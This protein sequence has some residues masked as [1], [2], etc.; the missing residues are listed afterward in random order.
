MWCEVT[1][2]MVGIV[3]DFTGLHRLLVTV[4]IGLFWI[5]E[6]TTIAIRKQKINPR[7][8]RYHKSSK[9]ASTVDGRILVL[10]LNYSGQCIMVWKISFGVQVLGL[11]C[12]VL[13]GDDGSLKPRA[14]GQHNWQYCLH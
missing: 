11:Q 13:H 4:S 10:Y 8:V 6:I 3:E 7:K 1:G 5:G 12:S 14:T 9:E 2:D